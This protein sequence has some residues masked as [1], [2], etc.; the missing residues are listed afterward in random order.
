MESELHPTLQCASAGSLSLGSETAVYVGSVPSNK[1]TFMYLN[2]EED[3]AAASEP[4]NCQHQ[5]AQH[6]PTV[7]SLSC[8]RHS[9]NGSAKPEERQDVS[10]FSH[11]VRHHVV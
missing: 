9:G 1:S 6:R 10:A 2:T 11:R 5:A 8:R 3:A 4:L 7:V